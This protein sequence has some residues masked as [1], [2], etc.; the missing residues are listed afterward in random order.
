MPNGMTVTTGCGDDCAGSDLKGKFSVTDILMKK[1]GLSYL[2]SKEFDQNTFMKI[3]VFGDCLLFHRKI[4]PFVRHAHWTNRLVF[5]FLVIG[6]SDFH[7]NENLSVYLGKGLFGLWSAY[8]LFFSVTFGGS[9]AFTLMRFLLVR[10]HRI[11]ENEDGSLHISI[12]PY[13]GP[14][15]EVPWHVQIVG[16]VSGIVIFTLWMAVGLAIQSI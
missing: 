6:F 8:S 4:W 5:L 16:W 13:G 9:V 11:T 2:L 14:R 7:F 3:S 1:S 12:T 15:V 10:Q